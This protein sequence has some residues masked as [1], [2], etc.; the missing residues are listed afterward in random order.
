LAAALLAGDERAVVMPIRQK[1]PTDQVR[2]RLLDELRAMGQAPTPDVLERMLF[3]PLPRTA[4]MLDR[5]V[6]DLLGPLRAFNVCAL[7]H[8]AGSLSYFNAAKLRA[9]NQE[10]TRALLDL[11]RAL[12]VGRFVY[13]STAFASGYVDGPIPE[14]LH[15]APNNDPN[16]YTRSKRE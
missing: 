11:A 6:P 8:C 14:Q 16:E 5:L 12:G 10:L 3:V 7:V 1:N 13:V 4:V 9:G 15:P 2:A